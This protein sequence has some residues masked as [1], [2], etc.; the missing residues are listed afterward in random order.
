M[1]RD[2]RPVANSVSAYIRHGSIVIEL[3]WGNDLSKCAPEG[4]VDHFC[5]E[6]YDVQE[7]MT[8]YKEKNVNNVGDIIPA[9][10]IFL[11]FF[12]IDPSGERIELIHHFPD[13]S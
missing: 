13:A 2:M 6:V 12:I 5:L 11:C 1:Q 8:Y 7:T 3:A 4:I 9:N 10:Q